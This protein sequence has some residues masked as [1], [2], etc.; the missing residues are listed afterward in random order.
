[1]ASR[2]SPVPG[3]PGTNRRVDLARARLRERDEPTAPIA[4]AN[5]LQLDGALTP[6][7]VLARGMSRSRM[8]GT[9]TATLRRCGQVLAAALT[10]S[11]AAPRTDTLVWAYA[12]QRRCCGVVRRGGRGARCLRGSPTERGGLS[13]WPRTRPG[14]STTTTS[15]PSTSCLASSARV[16][17]WPRRP[18]SRWGSPWIDDEQIAE[19][20]LTEDLLHTAFLQECHVAA[21]GHLE[22]LGHLA[23]VVELRVFGCAWVKPRW[24]DEVA[25]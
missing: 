10:S 12:W 24:G 11:D 1:M 17:G 25:H 16:R 14:C 23:K 6:H 13:S 9:E 2:S 7:N 4:R 5:S 18:C 8:S 20:L 22:W 19:V 3:W 15:A 21:L